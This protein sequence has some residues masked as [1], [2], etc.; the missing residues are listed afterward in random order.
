[1][2]GMDIKVDTTPRVELEKG[3]YTGTIVDVERRIT[4]NAA[5][6]EVYDY[7]DIVFALDG[8][9]KGKLPENA[10]G[11]KLKF[12]APS[13]VSYGSKLSGILKDAGVEL[14][15]GADLDVKKSLI[16]KAAELTV[17]KRKWTSKKDGVERESAEIKEVEFLNRKA[18]KP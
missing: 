9:R 6:G 14:V 10:Y 15:H 17:G 11:A 3:I 12:G 13:K 8:M 7:V 1:M 18:E 16:G 5:T 4:T 2:A